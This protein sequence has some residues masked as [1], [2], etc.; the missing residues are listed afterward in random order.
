MPEPTDRSGDYARAYQDAL[1]HLGV[2]HMN[3]GEYG[4]ALEALEEAVE[5]DFPDGEA[6]LRLGQ[7]QCAVGRVDEGK[8]TLSALGRVA[9]RMPVAERPSLL[10]LGKYQVGLC[11]QHAVDQADGTVA[12]VRAGGQAVRDLQ[13]FID[14]AEGLSDPSPAVARALTDARTRIEDIR[15]RVR[16]G[17]DAFMDRS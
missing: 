15:E 5:Y 9:R 11:S 10:A 6:Y 7:A 16:G 13:A 12:L 2:S 17:G 1:V 3:L 14:E 8:G 4:G